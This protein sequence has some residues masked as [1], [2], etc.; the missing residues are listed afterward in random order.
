MKIVF[1]FAPTTRSLEL[2][3]NKLAKSCHKDRKQLSANSL[4]TCYLLNALKIPQID[5][6][7]AI[8]ILQK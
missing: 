1:A 7:K 4:K 2:S 5:D 6:K 3:Y 8:N